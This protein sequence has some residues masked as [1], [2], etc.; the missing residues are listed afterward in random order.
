MS[1]PPISSGTDWDAQAA[2]YARMMK[3]GPMMTPNRAMLE[4]MDDALPFSSA[5]GIADIGCG[6][7]PAIKEL[8]DVYGSKI[9]PSARLV[10]SDFSE[11]MVEQVRKLQAKQ[12]GDPLW[13]RL[14]THVWDLQDLGLVAENSFSHVMGSLVFFIPEKPRQALSEVNRVLEKGGLI[15][16][17]SWHI[18]TWMDLMEAA[19][20]ATRPDLTAAV[21]VL[22]MPKAWR[23]V[24]AVK[25]ELEATGFREVHA[26]YAETYLPTENPRDLIR[27]FT[28]GKN[29][30]L[31]HLVAGFGE[32]DLEKLGDEF[33]RL[34]NEECPVGP[35]RLK[36]VAI[37]ATARK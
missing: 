17:T 13:E 15:A 26:E 5:T 10:A 9:S 28:K 36:G 25:N 19:A 33:E 35:K 16:L 12:S 23:T 34:V 20:R 30:L 31:A 2:E 37:V 11:G 32:E 1:S 24:D 27:W 6:P 7:G 29:P 4:R 21:K 3:D 18:V 8:L 22:E 14:E